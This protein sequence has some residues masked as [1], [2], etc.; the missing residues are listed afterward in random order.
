MKNTEKISI[1]LS[2]SMLR[3]IRAAVA[4]GEYASMS[5]A[6][7]DAVRTWQRLRGEDTERFANF[8]PPAQQALV[9]P[10]P[11]LTKAESM[12]LLDALLDG[13]TS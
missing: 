11:T 9:G 7:R 1:A 6:L 3:D 4:A 12:A 10:R 5:E 2:E 13:K 8:R